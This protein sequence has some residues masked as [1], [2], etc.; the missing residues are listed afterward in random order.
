LY[1]GSMKTDQAEEC[2]YRA[3]ELVKAT[4]TGH[5]T[6]DR[7]GIN[8]RVRVELARALAR[9]PR[10]LLVDEP[11]LIPQ[12]SD[13]DDFYELLHELAKELGLAMVIA[14]EEVTAVRGSHRLMNLDG[15]LYAKEPRRKV[16]EL[17]PGM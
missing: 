13:A 6:T 12:P 5:R 1:S 17:R 10:L 7:L 2:A 14:S 15:Q 8:D 11:A 3:L 4:H 16:V 9:E